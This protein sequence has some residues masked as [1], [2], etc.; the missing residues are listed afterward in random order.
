MWLTPWDFSKCSRAERY[1]QMIDWLLNWKYYL[2]TGL[3]SVRRQ[4][5]QN[6]MWMWY[7]LENEKKSVRG[8]TCMCTTYAVSFYFYI[9][10]ANAAGQR[11]VMFPIEKP[12]THVPSHRRSK[13]MCWRTKSPIGPSYFYVIVGYGLYILGWSGNP[14]VT[15]I[16]HGNELVSAWLDTFITARFPKELIDTRKYLLRHLIHETW[17][18]QC[19]TVHRNMAKAGI[20][21][22]STSNRTKEEVNNEYIHT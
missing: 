17:N 14:L 16:S 19:Y 5:Y 12:K 6:E 11:Y 20:C 1:M 22:I 3:M 18:K 21:R 8:Y 7:F 4:D 15:S 2:P 10:I 9:Y 13:I